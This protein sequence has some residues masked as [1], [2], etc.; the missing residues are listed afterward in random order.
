MEWIKC[1]YP[2]LFGKTREEKIEFE[3]KQMEIY[4]ERIGHMNI[5]LK[6]C[7]DKI[8]VEIAWFSSHR[9]DFAS[10]SRIKNLIREKA[11]M[12]TA[13]DRWETLKR[14][15]IAFQANLAYECDASQLKE[16]IDGYNTPATLERE[17]KSGA[18]AVAEQASDTET[19]INNINTVLTTASVKMDRGVDDEMEAMLR[20]YSA[21]SPTQISSMPSVPAQRKI[22]VRKAVS[23][24][25]KEKVLT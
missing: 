6:R 1:V 5:E 3:K 2:L 10:E 25:I 24:T 11:T 23:N 17:A 15:S 4:E 18:D 8:A 7:S 13:I 21:V 20:N 12:S 22:T 14:T 19:T 16:I 9:N